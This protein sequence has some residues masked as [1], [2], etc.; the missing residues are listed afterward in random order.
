MIPQMQR[1]R[2]RCRRFR[3]NHR[4]RVTMC[5]I[6]GIFRTDGGPVSATA[7]QQMAAAMVHR[8]PD[9]G[10]TWVGHG[11][12]LAHRRLA[13]ID[14]AG[15]NQPMANEDGT[16][17]VVFN[18]EI[19]NFPE[20]RRRLEARG[21]VFR[22]SS[23]TE[24]LVHLYEEHG[25]DMPAELNGMFAFAVVDV[26]RRRLLLARDRLGQKPLHYFF[27]KGR[28]T[29]A[30]ELYALSRAAAF[31]RD[32]RSQSIH[33]YL[34][35]Q[36]VPGPHTVYQ[37][38]L[39]LPPGSLL[40]C[41]A[42]APEPRVREF[43][44]LDFQ[45]KTTECFSDCAVRLRELLRDAV[46][47][48][49]M[50]DVPLG[51][52]LSGGIDSTITVGLMTEAA[53]R[54]IE[55]FSI[56]FPEPKY[57]ERRF[58]R[59]AAERFATRH[60]VRV[61]NPRDFGVVRRLV[62]HFGGPFSDAS[63]LPTFL[64]AGFTR[65]HV[66]VALSGDGADELFGGYYRYVVMQWT[67]LYDLLPAALRR[68]AVTALLRA[69]PRRTEERTFA[70][71]LRRVLE[72]G[73]AR[74]FPRRYLDLV[75]RFPETLKQGVYGPVL[76]EVDLEPSCAVMDAAF[77]AAGSRH[78]AERVSEVDVHTYLPGD[79]LQKV[80]ITS[81]A[82]SL[83]VRS[84]FLDHR[85]AEFAAALP[86]Q[87]KQG[88][89]QRKRIL[90]AACADLLPPSVARRPKMGFGVPLA[91]WFRGEWERPLR[92]VLLD[93]GTRKRGFFR[94]EAVETL[95]RE[96]CELRADHSYALWA[97]LVLELWFQEVHDRL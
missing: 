22:S 34:T 24:V 71:R 63:M 40:L 12:G 23:D 25:P 43:W 54:P 21:H 91:R 32:I 7:L 68:P 45:S 61:V 46:R 66:T 76:S 2:L 36:Y 4:A 57:D 38:V 6:A 13:I 44:R 96:H 64:L 35:L 50:S 78:P 59:T 90:R 19:Y 11:A 48:R 27:R 53:E 41:S 30:S 87:F 10:G 65:E 86:W 51:A 73:A 31:P 1:S 69:V 20:L 8:G 62:R 74:T 39:S 15:G 58:A 81:M 67:R 60:H 42:D 80:D 56:G 14:I 52:F 79:I 89:G 9:A 97:L 83:E 49:L 94:P 75:S 17:Q 28:L 85:V 3:D 16:V 18:G 47:R 70:G 88:R 84:P 5:G 26:S 95:I 37:G 72:L 92:E 82:T 55:T 33:D 93:P 77:A 29:F